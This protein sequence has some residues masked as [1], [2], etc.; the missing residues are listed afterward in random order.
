M[1]SLDIKDFVKNPDFFAASFKRKDLPGIFEKKV[2]VPAGAVALVTTREGKREVA[3]AGEARADLDEVLFVREDESGIGFDVHALLSGN[4]M[5]FQVSLRLVLGIRKEEIDLNLFRRNILKGK[6]TYTMDDLR[7][8]FSPPVREFLTSFVRARNADEL[9]QPDMPGHLGQGVR[10]GLKP[11]LFEGG[12]KLSAVH[13]IEIRSEPFEQ[14]KVAAEEIRSEERV[15]ALR[16][17]LSFRQAE[18]AIDLQSKLKEKR[19]D[20]ALRRYEDIRGRLGN[21][22]LRATIMLLQDEKTKARLIKTLI[23]KEMPEEAKEKLEASRLRSDVKGWIS[24]L[25]TQMRMR[26]GDGAPREI[27]KTLYAVGGKEVMELDAQ[28]FGPRARPKATHDF[29]EGDLGYLRSV[30]FDQGKGLLLVGAQDGVYVKDSK[31]GDVREFP[32]PNRGKGRGGVNSIALY[33]SDLFATHS[34][35]GL[36]KWDLHGISRGEPILKEATSRN[37]STRSAQVADG[38]LFFSTGSEVFGV[39]LVKWKSTSFRGFGDPITA[40][41]VAPPY[42]F[43]GTKLGVILRWKIEEPDNPQALNLREANPIYMMKVAPVSNTVSLIIGAK[44]FRVNV[45]G[46]DDDLITAF[47]SGVAIRW[48]DGASDAV[49]GVDREGYR[50]Y[51]WE[52]GVPQK[53]KASIRLDEKVQDIHLTREEVDATA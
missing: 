18:E 27:A 44:D 7:D 23:E 20:E 35:Q 41:A 28:D 3:K 5:P 52:A 12:I 11:Y 1:A 30:R 48:V 22:D 45:K 16:Q 13:H 34:E 40:V 9:Y 24:E 2:R 50:I 14:E 37:S 51:V 31:T 26:L 42:L 49:Y 6:K 25:A 17:A 21:D 4:G 36:V 33:G 15:E 32:F 38:K 39:D 10:E 8:Y 53:P 47:L 19:V 29:S 46:I 43:A